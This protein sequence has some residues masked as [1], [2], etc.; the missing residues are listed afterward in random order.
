MIK[1]KKIHLA[2]V[3]EMDKLTSMEMKCVFGGNGEGTTSFTYYP[4]H[5]EVPDALRVTRPFICTP[6]K[7]R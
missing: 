3:S 5:T 6:I 1:L 4:N 2:E 7:Q